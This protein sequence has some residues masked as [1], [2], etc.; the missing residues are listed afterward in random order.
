MTRRTATGWIVTLIASLLIAPAVLAAEDKPAP[1]PSK[2]MVF[3]ESSPKFPGA[4]K[5]AGGPLERL[6]GITP[7]TAKQHL[8]FAMNKRENFDFG[9]DGFQTKIVSNMTGDAAMKSAEDAGV[10]SVLLL[11]VLRRAVK[12]IG[13]SEMIIEVEASYHLKS[14]NSARWSK[15]Y[16]KVFKA[17]SLGIQG[18]KM[19]H[20][21]DVIARQMEELLTQLLF[22]QVLPNRPRAADLRGTPRTITVQ[23][24]NG[25][26]R[27]VVGLEMEVPHGRGESFLVTSDDAIQPGEKRDVVFNLP[28]DAPTTSIAWTK[29]ALTDVTFTRESLDGEALG[30]SDA[31]RPTLRERLERLR[32]RRTPGKRP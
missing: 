21:V 13:Q 22:K 8:A 32:Q 6:A 5:K 2:V 19:V 15:K 16:S 11:T 31:N 12:D 29:G 3:I 24:T 26:Q 14:D 4:Q 20:D 30:A 25:A 17:E 1:D 28:S 7:Q 10:G 9:R 27:S 18:G 23:V